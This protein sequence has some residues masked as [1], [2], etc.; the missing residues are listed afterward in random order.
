MIILQLVE[1]MH[2]QYQRQQ[3]G[4]LFIIGFTVALLVSNYSEA[5]ILMHRELF[6]ILFLAMPVSML[7]QVSLSQHKT[8]GQL[9]PI[10]LSLPSRTL[11]KLESNA[12]LRVRRRQP[13]LVTGG[14]GFIGSHMVRML[15]AE[16]HKIVVY[17]NLKRGNRDAVPAD[18]LEVG[19][20]DDRR[21]LSSLFAKHEFDAVLHFAALAYVGESVSDPSSYYNNNVAGTLA[22]IDTMCAHEVKRLV[23]SSTC[24][25]Y[26]QHR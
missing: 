2:C 3:P 10:P 1:L 5:R 26:G 15:L 16:G 19:E 9:T 8:A 23:F 21:K 14:A 4:V 12:P 25:T 17:D 24:A 20:L 18:M 13:L 11:S 7:Q 22:L 6:W